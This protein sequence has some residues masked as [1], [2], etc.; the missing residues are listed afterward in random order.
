MN[1]AIIARPGWMAFAGAQIDAEQHRHHALQLVLCEGEALCETVDESIEGP[2][3][4]ASQIPH[5][6]HL[7]NGWIVLIEPR[8][9]LGTTMQERL[10]DKELIPIAAHLGVAA[11]DTVGLESSLNILCGSDIGNTC[12]P[13]NS[14]TATSLDPR[15][16]KLLERLDQCLNGECLKPAQ[17]SARSLAGDLALSESRFRHLFR[18]EM[19]IAWRPYLR[20]RRAQCAILAMAS[21][22]SATDAAYSAGFA[23]SAH[24]ARSVRSLFGLNI[25]SAKRQLKADRNVE[26]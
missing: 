16:R 14:A 19:G 7:K 21:G 18:A 20:W 17:W 23:D 5:R 15:I 11:N 3:L 9:R 12:P 26:R 10:G 4:L 22:N 6:Q 13:L 24:L 1:P 8:S 2:C 25:R